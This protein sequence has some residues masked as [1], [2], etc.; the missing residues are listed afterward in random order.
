MMARLAF[1]A[2]L[3]LSAA[4]GSPH[5]Q[6]GGSRMDGVVLDSVNRRPLAGATVQL[7]AAPPAHGSFGATTDSL[8]RFHIDGV[9]PGSYVAGFLHP[10]LDTLGV[11]APYKSIVLGEGDTHVTLAV[12]SAASL[13][14][15]VCGA[16]AKRSA[17]PDSIGMLVGHVRDAST[18]AT[19]GGS[20][21]VLDWPALVFGGGGARTEV[22]H[23]RART[24]DDGWFAMCGLEADE[25]HVHAEQ[26]ARATGDI[27]IEVRPRAITRLS[28]VIGSDSGASGATLSGIVRAADGKPLEG[29][30]VGVDGSSTTAATD[31][32][33]AFALSNLPDGTRMVE[34][35]ALGYVPARAPIEPSRN[36]PRA[37]A[38]VMAKRAAALQ[39][40][41]VF[42][43]PSW[44]N[45]DFTGFADRRRKGFGHFI[46]REQIAQTNDVSICDLLSRVPGV[47]T[48]SN[49]GIGCTATLHGAMT[50]AGG[51][52]SSCEPKV[53]LNNLP[54]DGSVEELTRSFSPRDIMGIEIYSAATQ[55]IQY[56]GLCG[57]LV[58]WTR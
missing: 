47:L 43:K 22:R 14:S 4:F 50:G 15:A 46:T 57:S 58:V 10:L 53:Y 44:R 24:N 9:R 1:L 23:L 7:V 32:Q 26:G 48:S 55:P 38:V 25:Y 29:A 31:A 40:V 49:G 28:L 56:Q 34:V 8:G 30:Q 19:I 33:G 18:G 3:M 2:A 12:P 45:R 27:D 37:I 54:F 39:E 16:S 36:E 5:A 35:R 6:T 11:Q 51:T 20:A 13:M 42:G 21:I 41:T 17:G 52:I